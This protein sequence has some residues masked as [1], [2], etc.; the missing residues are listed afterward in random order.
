MKVRFAAGSKLGMGGAIVELA[1]DADFLTPFH[2]DAEV[3]D[4]LKLSGNAQASPRDVHPATIEAM[5]SP[6]GV[7]QD[8]IASDKVESLVDAP[9]EVETVDA[10]G[11]TET[12]VAEPVEIPHVT[13]K[14]SKAELVAVAESAGVE[15][16]PDS[17]TKAEIIEAIEKG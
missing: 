11:E 15:V 13:P 1:E 10:S 17:M 14:M 9:V 3:A 6:V 2:S 12:V 8:T 16:V 7:P 4:Y 5:E